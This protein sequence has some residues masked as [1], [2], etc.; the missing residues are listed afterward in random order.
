MTMCNDKGSPTFLSHC[1][2]AMS[3]LDLMFT[4]NAAHAANSVLEWKVAPE[5]P[6]GSDHYPLTWTVD[7]G[8]V[9]LENVTAQRFRWRGLKDDVLKKW[10]APYESE[11]GHCAWGLYDESASTQTL[12]IATQE[13]HNMMQATMEAHV[14]KRKDS[15]CTCPWWTLELTQAY[16]Y[17]HDLRRSAQI[18]L[19]I[20]EEEA[21]D[22]LALIKGT[23]NRLKWLTK[24]AKRKWIS[25]ELEKAVP[26]DICPCT[27]PP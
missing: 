9:A 11:V 24:A 12:D 22:T 17:L 7:Y 3:V 13:L 18:F 25:D 2:R 21:T 1:G 27:Q 10:K 14:P 6:H 8:A 19:K 15:I 4:N 16:N 23:R 26:D 5:L 20:V